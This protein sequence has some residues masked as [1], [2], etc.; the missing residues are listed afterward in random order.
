MSWYQT[1]FSGNNGNKSSASRD[2]N[3][4][5]WG[6]DRLWMPAGAAKEIVF[7]DAVPFTFYEHNAR[8]NGNW[9]NWTTCLAPVTEEGEPECCRILGADTRYRVSMLTIIDCTKWT[10]KKGNTRQYEI[11]VLPAKYKT[12][13]KLERKQADLAEQ[14]KSLTGRLYRVVR[15]T[16]K[17]PAVGD[18]YE[19]VREVDMTKLF[20]LATYK[21]KKLSE[22]YAQAENDPDFAASMLKVLA[23]TKNADGSL[24]KSVPPLRYDLVFA[25]K[26]PGE[27][28][29]SFGGYSAQDQTHSSFDGADEE[30]PF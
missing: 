15:E 18:D 20:E 10:D 11:K 22:L 29:Q 12:S 23:A 21:N 24:V 26:T 14:G 16:D 1:G 6:P 30:I 25:P 27:V 5:S 8:V 19:F 2:A 9:K 17:S 4:F 28:K 13:Q 7:V 3:I